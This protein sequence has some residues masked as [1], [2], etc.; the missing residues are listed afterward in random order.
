M[1]PELEKILLEK[2]PKIFVDSNKS[3]RESAMAW[4]CECGD[5]WFDII[6][7]LCQ[8]LS[9][10]YTSAI[11][12]GSEG[13]MVVDAPAVVA[14]QIKEKFGTLRFYYR[15]DVKKEILRSCEQS[16]IG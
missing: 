4:G 3:S 2:Y 14:T 16:K 6:D 10:L 13:Y 15:L 8:T 12:V 5:G 9:N 7:R 11:P 1:K